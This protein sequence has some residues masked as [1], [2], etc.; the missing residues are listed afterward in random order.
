MRPKQID[1]Y[2]MPDKVLAL[3]TNTNADM[4]MRMREDTKVPGESRRH[5]R[6]K[7]ICT[8]S[9]AQTRLERSTSQQLVRRLARVPRHA[10]AKHILLH[11]IRRGLWL[12]VLRRLPSKVLQQLVTWLALT[13]RVEL[14]QLLCT[15][16]HRSTKSLWVHQRSQCRWWGP[17][18]C[19]AS[20]RPDC[21]SS[22]ERRHDLRHVHAHLARQ[23]R[24]KIHE[25]S[26]QLRHLRCQRQ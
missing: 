15:H 5:M 14:L 8:V 7:Q 16:L 26:L 4:N 24:N 12:L 10:R 23:G 25:H 22:G 13:E 9:N 11:I 17:T 2:Y 18:T 19:D 1:V 20:C 3:C 6:E 21:A